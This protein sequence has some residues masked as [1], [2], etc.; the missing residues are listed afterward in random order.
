LQAVL[1]LHNATNARVYNFCRVKEMV[2]YLDLLLCL[3][4]FVNF[5]LL[6]SAAVI[7]KADIKLWRLIA[8]AMI[9]AVSSLT[10]LLPKIPI[11]LDLW[12]KIFVSALMTLAAFSFCSIKIFARRYFAMLL[13]S[14]SF[15]GVMFAVWLAFRP[16]GMA[17]SGNAVYFNISPM[18]LVVSTVV[19]YLIIRLIAYFTE[20]KHTDKELFTLSITLGERT[21]STQALCDTGNTLTDV[22]SGNPV[23]VIDKSIMQSLLPEYAAEFCAAASL[24]PPAIKER[25]RIIPYRAVGGRGFLPAFVPD[26]IEISSGGK[27]YKTN[28]VTVAVSDELTDENY[29][30]L[31]GSELGGYLN[32]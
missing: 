21:V 11:V 26:C 19:A 3:N 13:C 18:L 27:K 29:R 32:G 14:F 25:Y 5:F 16:K 22:L 1:F 30:A 6:K 10:I 4:L 31:I 23:V 12:I 24:P 17:V 8:A 7:S 2:I 15:A 20:R 28:K 9:G